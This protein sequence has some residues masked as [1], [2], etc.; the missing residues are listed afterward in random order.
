LWVLAPRLSQ[1]KADNPQLSI[2]KVVDS[3]WTEQGTKHYLAFPTQKF[4]IKI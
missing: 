1:D 4:G 3:W 2:I